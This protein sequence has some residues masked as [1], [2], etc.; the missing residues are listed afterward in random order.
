MC[1]NTYM[2][3]Q[4][5]GLECVCNMCVRLCTCVYIK[6]RGVSLCVLVHM[7]VFLPAHVHFW[8]DLF[9]CCFEWNRIL[10]VY[11]REKGK[12]RDKQSGDTQM[13]ERKTDFDLW[14]EEGLK[15]CPFC[16][17][18]TW[19]MSYTSVCNQIYWQA[20][21]EYVHRK[22]WMLFKW[23]SVEL[24]HV[25][26]VDFVNAP[27]INHWFTIKGEC[28]SEWACVLAFN[29]KYGTMA[30]KGEFWACWLKCQLV[31]F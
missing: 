31:F 18:L 25:L 12:K 22:Q 3:V 5:G 4:L 23:I 24:I 26:T 17:V 9:V 10:C 13:K 19:R 6:R 30:T 1:V 16:S 14:N 7:C 2:C 20:G 8:F 27:M 21:Q 11:G 28:V 15:A 29:S